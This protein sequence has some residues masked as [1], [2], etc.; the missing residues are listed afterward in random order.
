MLT[1]TVLGCLAALAAASPANADGRDERRHAKHV[2]HVKHTKHSRHAT[3]RGD[4]PRSIT[5]GNGK[6]N[7]S[8]VEVNSP[9][10]QRGNQHTSTE[11][12]GGITNVQSALCKNVRVCHVTLQVIVQAPKEKKSKVK[13][14]QA[15]ARDDED[16]DD[17]EAAGTVTKRDDD[18][19]C[20]CPA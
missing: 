4:D 14:T 7:R 9:T 17:D 3:T 8:I 13:N 15:I 11:N 20:C 1:L 5:A 19:E 6:R 10:N 12:L 16:D 2:K 18:E